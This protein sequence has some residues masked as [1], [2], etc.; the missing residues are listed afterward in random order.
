M[1]GTDGA[2]IPTNLRTLLILETI[3][4]RTSPMTA[5]VGAMKTLAPIRGRTPLNASII[6]PLPFFRRLTEERVNYRHKR[7]RPLRLAR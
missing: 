7:L 3:G 2:R 5:A 4:S 6:D 1:D